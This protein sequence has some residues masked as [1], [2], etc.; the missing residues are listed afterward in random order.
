MMVSGIGN[1][2]AGM[3]YNSARYYNYN[4]NV[5]QRGY[6]IQRHQGNC[7]CHSS[8]TSFLNRYSNI[9]SNLTAS[10]NALRNFNTSGIIGDYT[11]TSSN[12]DVASATLRWSI[13]APKDIG[14]DVDQIARSQ[15]NVSGSINGSANATSNMNFQINNGSG[16]TNVSVNSLNTDGTTKTNQQMFEEAAQQINGSKGDYQARVVENK[17]M[18]SLEIESEKTG[19]SNQFNITGSF[20]AAS[21]IDNVAVSAENAKYRVT[22]NGQTRSY[23]SESNDIKLELGKIGVTL[24]GV[25]RTDISVHSNNDKIV[26]AFEELINNYNT[27]IE[28]LGDNLDR[29]TGVGQQ[30]H[31]LTRDPMALSSM[32]RLGIKKNGD[33]TLVFDK[34][35][36]KNNLNNNPNLTKDLLSGQFGFAQ[37]IYQRAQR[38]LSANPERLVNQEEDGIFSV[39]YGYGNRKSTPLYNRK[40][41]YYQ[42]GKMTDYYF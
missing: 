35:A 33:G 22:S 20:G 27:A 14:L 37:R 34:D 26:S 8:T 41:Y 10:A 11:V 13:G 32:K 31:N 9:M 19:T 7:S 30:L 42:Q 38:A 23:T 3:Y 39:S 24:K 15:K 6:R 17:G 2:R 21:G 5:N 12:T 29:G 28:Y 16:T 25:G 1:Y 40:G 18:V 36:F 4:T